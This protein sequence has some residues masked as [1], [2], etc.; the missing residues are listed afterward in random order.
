MKVLN[1]IKSG[2][3]WCYMA[4]RQHGHLMHDISDKLSVKDNTHLINIQR[5]IF[6]GNLASNGYTRTDR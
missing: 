2:W 3:H 5:R 1:K 4:A 6:W